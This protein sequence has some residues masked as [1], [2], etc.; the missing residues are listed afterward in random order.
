MV[1]GVDAYAK[2]RKLGLKAYHNSL[3]KRLNPSLPVLEEIELS[4]R[5]KQK[6]LFSVMIR[7]IAPICLVAI[8]A[9]SILGAFGVISI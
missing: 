5:F 1:V 8:L 3:Q 6:R 9:S 4:E 7:Y 2:A